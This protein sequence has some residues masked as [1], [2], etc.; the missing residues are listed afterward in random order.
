MKP[1]DEGRPVSRLVAY[2]TKFR[3]PERAPERT[4]WEK[5]VE[6]RIRFLL[7]SMTAY[8]MPGRSW[9]VAA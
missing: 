1:K 5:S 3:R 6:R 7:E 9:K 4:V 8:L 2:N